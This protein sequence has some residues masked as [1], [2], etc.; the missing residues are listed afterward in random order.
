MRPALSSRF[1]RTSV[2]IAVIVTVG[3]LL[4][5]LFVALRPLPGRDVTIATGPPGSVYAQ[6]AERY[7][8]ILARDG[9]R[10]R[11]V[12]TRGAVEN[13]ERLRDA[14]SGVDA[15]FVQAGTTDERESPDLVSL[16]T[17]FYE[18]LWVF[19]REGSTAQLLRDLPNAT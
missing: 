19:R 17:L 14:R 11:L 9:V 18:P 4:W 15:G 3:V 2:G 8:E 5:A 13:L 10:L 16:G 6:A 12:P 7:R 1:L